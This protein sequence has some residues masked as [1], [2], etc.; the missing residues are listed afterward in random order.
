MCDILEDCGVGQ[1]WGGSNVV[2]EEGVLSFSV[3]S[4][5][6]DNGV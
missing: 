3:G 6:V 4:T 2:D 1:Y 5:G